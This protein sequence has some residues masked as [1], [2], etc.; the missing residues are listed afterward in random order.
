ME[1]EEI[2]QKTFKF[3]KYNGSNNLGKKVII[4]KCINCGFEKE[5]RKDKFLQGHISKCDCD[6]FNSIELKNKQKYN[7]YIGKKLMI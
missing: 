6:E 7:K 5:V 3:L 1:L 4:V 2:Q